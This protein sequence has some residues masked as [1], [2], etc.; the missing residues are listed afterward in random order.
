MKTK[1]LIYVVVSLLAFLSATACRHKDAAADRP[2][3]TVSIEPQRWAL[4]RL[5]GDKVE[6]CTLLARGGNP[7]NYEPTFAHLTSLERSAAY[8][9]MGN[10]GFEDAILRKVRANLPSLPIY[11]ASDSIPLIHSGHSHDGAAHS[12]HDHGIDPHVWSSPRNMRVMARN[13]LHVLCRIDTA[14]TPYYTDRYAALVKH[15]DSID[16]LCDSILSPVRG[17]TFIVWHPSLSYFARDYGL[18]QLSLGFEGKE[19]S[20]AQA[21]HIADHADSARV[22]LIQK[23]FDPHQAKALTSSTATHTIDPLNYDWD[24]ELVN[25]ARAIARQ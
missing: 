20:V 11:C 24:T 4:E 12:G 9:T 18:R 21:R 19:H 3:V 2:T 16:H 1:P 7:E 8:I 17:Q 15:I 6:V 5:A 13:M 23:D 25:T 14:N 10:L 22:F